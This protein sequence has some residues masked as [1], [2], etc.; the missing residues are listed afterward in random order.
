MR[1]SAASEWPDLCVFVGSI[2]ILTVPCGRLK[3]VQLRA[4]GQSRAETLVKAMPFSVLSWLKKQQ[5]LLVISRSI[6]TMLN[7]NITEEE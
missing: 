1:C 3:S 2:D 5:Q 6:R 7:P 4:P